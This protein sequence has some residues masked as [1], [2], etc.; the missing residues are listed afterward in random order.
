MRS[1]LRR[2]AELL[3]TLPLSLRVIREMHYVLLHNVRG[4]D[5]APGEFRRIQVHI[6]PDRRYIP[7][8]PNDVARCLDALE[9]FLNE[10]DEIEPL[11]RAFLAH[12]QF[13]AIHPFIDGNGRVGRALHPHRRRR[14]PIR[15][16]LSEGIRGAGDLR[17]CVRRESRRASF[18]T[19][20]A[21]RRDTNGQCSPP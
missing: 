12:Y 3:E 21:A 5:R 8:P 14:A 17:C 15:R 10:A 20:Q 7:P 16:R 4:R 9:H 13:E 19:L 6:G 11:V 18:L 1:P 2:G